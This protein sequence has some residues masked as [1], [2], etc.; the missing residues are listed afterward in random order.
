M[1]ANAL[2]I[3]ADRSVPLVHV[4]ASTSTGTLL[5]PVG[6]EGATRLLLRLMRR[7]T[8]GLSAEALA[9]AIDRLGATLGGEANR[10]VCGFHGSVI[11]R[12]QSAYFEL[13][14]RVMTD[15]NFDEEE[16]ALIQAEAD[17][18]WVESLDNDSSLALKFFSREF[19]GA[20][21]YGRVAS[22]TRTSLRSL[23]LS[24]LR[25]IYHRH[26]SG[27]LTFAFAGDVELP[28][29]SRFTE[30][31]ERKLNA[32]ET[33]SD[34][35]PPPEG[36]RGRNLVFV[37][38]PSRTQTQ[39]L[40][41]C[42]GSHPQDDDHVAL[43]LGHTIFGGTF[44][45]R[46]SREV[47]GKRGWSYGAS[48]HLPYDRLRQ[49]FY[50][51][52]FPAAEDAAPCLSLKLKL[53]EQLI[54]R[55]VTKTELLSAKKYLKNSNVFSRDTA[56][57]RASEQLDARTYQLPL[58]YHD[59]FVDKIMETRLEDVNSALRARLS[60]KNLLITVLGTKTDIYPSIAEA[61]PELSAS[62]IVNYDRE[63]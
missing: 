26:F 5:D 13:L 34:E 60:A 57:K 18:E 19:F 15:V 41:G 38:K 12:N 42:L 35:L 29:A 39:I 17:A 63:D 49:S 53:L 46:L 45:A 47:R 24:D 61:I 7:S 16:F 44:S 37:D 20:H 56:A 14:E 8:V 4:S 43:F 28:S 2:I 52:T 25:A 10:S 55:G 40:V 9:E 27:A 6:K 54:D 50:A 62:K 1:S 3:E 32:D 33:T 21:P 59:S 23:G 36:P 31:V 30:A 48:S 58:G 51:W 11:R 22:G